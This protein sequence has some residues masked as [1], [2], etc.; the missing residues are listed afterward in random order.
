MRKEHGGMGLRHFHGLNLAL[1]GK[2]AWKG[3]FFRFL[4]VAKTNDMK[5][6]ELWSANSGGVE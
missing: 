1:L 6:R 2:H 4:V 5:V 3:H